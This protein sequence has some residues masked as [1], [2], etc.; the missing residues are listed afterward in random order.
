MRRMAASSPS[1]PTTTRPRHLLRYSLRRLLIFLTLACVGVWWWFRVP[2]KKE[3]LHPKGIPIW[4]EKS[5]FSRLVK[6]E[7]RY[8]RVLRGEPIREGL[9]EWFD[10]EGHRLGEEHWREGNLHGPWVRWYSTGIVREKGEYDRGRKQGLW[11]QFDEQGQIAVRMPFD[12]GAPDGQWERFEGGKLFRTIRFDHTEV[13]QIDG[14]PID[15]PLGRA[16]RLGQIENRFVRE[17]LPVRGEC[18]FRNNP[19]KDVVDYIS[20]NYKVNVVLNRRTLNDVGV[21]VDSPISLRE[22]QVTT[23]AMLVL[24]FEPHGLAAT[25]RFGMIWITT[26]EDAKSWVDRTGIA[27]LLKSPPPKVLPGDRDKIRAAFEQRAEF[28]FLDTPLQDIAAFLSEFYRVPLHCDQG[29]KDMPLT[30][31]LR[32]VSLQNAL[33]AVCDQYG[34]CVRWKDGKTLLIESQE[35]TETWRPRR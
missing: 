18:D 29:I 28:D 8:R 19:L 15:D 26:K 12:Q 2:Y 1:P 11:E 25:Y 4:K 14:R 23:G 33:S 27:E 22:S 30:S 3:V 16:C 32:G 20:E 7:Q 5:G 35:G 10:A 6:E 24:L 31:N 13:T 21:Q 34:L 17:M 9:T